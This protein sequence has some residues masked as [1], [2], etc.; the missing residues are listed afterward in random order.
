SG[1]EDAIADLYRHNDALVGRVMG[2]LD[3]R[4]VLMVVSDHGFNAFRRGVNLNS[5]L[6]REGYL[7]LKPG[8]DGRAEWLRDVDWSATRAY[9]VG[10]TGMFL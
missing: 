1:H 8:S 5:W 7:A 6:H 3:D 2:Q 10:L 4:D 9:T